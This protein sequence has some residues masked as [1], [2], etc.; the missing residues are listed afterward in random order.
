MGPGG[1]LGSC[2]SIGLVKASDSGFH[3]EKWDGRAI[4]VLGGGGGG[5]A[6]RRGSGGTVSTWRNTHF[7]NEPQLRFR[8]YLGDGSAQTTA[9]TC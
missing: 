3:A 1:D 4:W 8:V 2:A 7:K 5:G 6:F 9:I